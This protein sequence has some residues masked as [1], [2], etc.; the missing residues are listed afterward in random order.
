MRWSA[1][2]RSRC[3]RLEATDERRARHGR[4]AGHGSSRVREGRTGVPRTLGGAGLRTQPCDAGLG[5]VEPRRRP[6]RART[7]AACRLSANELLRAMG[8]PA[9]GAG[10]EVWPG[11]Q[12][13]D[14]QRKGGS[15]LDRRPLRRSASRRPPAGSAGE[16]PRARIQRFDRCS[17]CASACAPGT[18]IP[19]ATRACR[20]TCA[21][22]PASSSGITASISFPTAT[23]IFRV[24]N[25]STSTPSVSRPRSCGGTVASPR[26]SVHLDLWDDYLERA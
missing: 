15:G 18:S 21:A 14:R 22:R 6:A 25:A 8:P 5:Q 20:A 11:E 9:G 19:P 4:S 1:L 12:G 17:R 16:F 24:R 2:P 3:R 10:C 23:R 13:G 7:H 26:D